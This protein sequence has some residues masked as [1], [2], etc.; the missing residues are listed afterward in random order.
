MVD[1]SRGTKDGLF[2]V[3][4]SKIG[5]PRLPLESFSR[6]KIS[7]KDASHIDETYHHFPDVRIP[8][9]GVF[10]VQVKHSLKASSVYL[11][12]L[13]TSQR[14]IPAPAPRCPIIFPYDIPKFSPYTARNRRAAKQLIAPSPI[15]SGNH[16]ASG[17]ITGGRFASNGIIPYLVA[18]FTA[19]TICTG[20]LISPRWV[21][22]AAHCAPSA[23]TTV[24]I[25]SQIAGQ[26]GYGLGVEQAFPHPM[27]DAKSDIGRSYDI[28]AVKLSV[29]VEN[30][31][32]R[33]YKTAF[34]KINAARQKPI[35]GAFVRV[36]GYG[37]THY[38]KSI[39]DDIPSALRQ[40]DVPVSD[41]ERCKRL[42]ANLLYPVKLYFERQL[43]TGY[44]RC[45]QWYVR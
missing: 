7:I 10:L 14:Q 12:D 44:D 9:Q 19:G 21:L 8:I 25:L 4:V 33:T 16:S 11:I 43:C 15:P 5:S 24:G 23:Y 39:R 26:T 30:C 17:Y 1:D 13:H 29:S 28:A 37:R 27:Y 34:M 41:N 38:H 32:G 20:T 31:C 18:L 36:A 35:T 6:R 45:D 22:T 40:V 3:L 2:D 42:Y